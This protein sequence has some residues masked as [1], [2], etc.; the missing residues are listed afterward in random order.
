M[1]PIIP[2]RT[3][4]AQRGQMP[5]ATA[6][7]ACAKALGRS[8]RQRMWC[9][10]KVRLAQA[11]R[12]SKLAGQALHGLDGSELSRP[13]SAID[14]PLRL[15][16]LSCACDLTASQPRTP[17]CESRSSVASR[18][19]FEVR[20]A[21][22]RVQVKLSLLWL[23]SLQVPSRVACWLTRSLLVPSRAPSKNDEQI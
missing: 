12:H 2:I 13:A 6:E 10:D 19:R 8:T 14:E 20:R 3:E 22:S 17:Q 11:L 1:R 5:P 7:C 15:P 21:A 9:H 16:T 4:K 18:A 23:E